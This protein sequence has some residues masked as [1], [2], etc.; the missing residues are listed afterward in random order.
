MQALG[1]A[2]FSFM[3][4]GHTKDYAERFLFLVERRSQGEIEFVLHM[5][6]QILKGHD[7]YLEG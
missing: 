2:P 4:Q 7:G 5:V 1:T 6:E 3:K